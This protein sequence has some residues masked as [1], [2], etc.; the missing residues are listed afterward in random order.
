[1]SSST[2]SSETFSFP[3]CFLAC[4]SE[5]DKVITYAAGGGGGPGESGRWRQKKWPSSTFYLSNVERAADFR[6]PFA[7][8]KNHLQYIA[9]SYSHLGKERGKGRADFPLESSPFLRP[10]RGHSIV[11]FEDLQKVPVLQLHRSYNFFAFL[12]KKCCFLKTN[13]VLFK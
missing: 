13:I 8:S 7:L 4:L 6:S 2:S 10:H 9:V 1:M 5:R 11:D 3:L 12:K